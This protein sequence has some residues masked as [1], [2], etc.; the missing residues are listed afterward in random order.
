AA[1]AP[2]TLACPDNEAAP[3][4]EGAERESWMH[5]EISRIGHD[6]DVEAIATDLQRVLR[7]VRE[8]VED[9]ERMRV[10]VRDIIDD[11]HASP[12]ATVSAA[13]LERGIAFLE[14]LAPDHVTF[15][16]Y[17]ADQPQDRPPP[18]PPPGVPAPPTRRP[19]DQPRPA[20]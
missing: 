14:W 5:V 10:Q 3:P 18:T 1:G 11:L 12:P 7:D 9:W 2:D 15:L 13:E 19:R 4:P 16:R 8:S 17:R 20:A 6:E